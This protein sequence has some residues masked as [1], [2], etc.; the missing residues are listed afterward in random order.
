M[1]STIPLTTDTGPI[2]WSKLTVNGPSI[3]HGTIT[4]AKIEPS[5][6]HHDGVKYK[7]QSFDDRP[8]IFGDMLRISWSITDFELRS[9][10]DTFHDV[11]QRYRDINGRKLGHHIKGACPDCVECSH[12]KVTEVQQV[13][14][15]RAA[16]N[17]ALTA[18]CDIGKN[19]GVMVRC[20]NG[21]FAV[22]KGMIALVPETAPLPEQ[23]LTEIP[24]T[25]VLKQESAP[26]I[27]SQERDRPTSAAP[28]AW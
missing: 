22:R 16:T 13:D 5:S 4:A 8:T 14:L 18:K 24:A 21:K 7:K 17:F 27:R 11:Q 25:E 20:P 10:V 12:L 2:D 19:E 6:L 1:A 28:D 3:T 9:A 26:Y 23:P 15:H